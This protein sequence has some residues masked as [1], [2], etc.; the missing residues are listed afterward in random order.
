[1][2]PLTSGT[3]TSYATIAIGAAGAGPDTTFGGQ[4]VVVDF[5]NFRVTAVKPVCPP[6]SQPK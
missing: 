5:D 1:M 3:N 6:G 4:Q 2:D